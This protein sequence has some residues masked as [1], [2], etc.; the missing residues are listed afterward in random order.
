V[1][2]PIN[3]DLAAGCERVVVIAPIP[4]IRGLPGGGLEEQL[5]PIKADGQ[6]IVIGPDEASRAAIGRDQQDLSRRPAAARAGFQQVPSL[7][8]ALGEHWHN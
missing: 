6:V 2:S 5:A 1:R 3:A 7:V 4:E 8:D